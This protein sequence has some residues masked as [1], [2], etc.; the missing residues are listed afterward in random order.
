MS[1]NIKHEC[2]I[3]MLRLRKPPDFYFNKYGTWYYGLQKMYLMMEKQHNRG[4]D[5][6]G[7]AGI[8]INV[9]PGHRYIFRQRS[10]R[11]DPIKEI[12]SLIYEDIDKINTSNRKDL[13]DPDFIRMDMPF[14]CDVYLGH[15][16]YGTYGNYRIDYVH[17]VSRENN[18][19]SKNL[20]MAGNF[21]L[22]NVN[23]VLNHLIDLGQ[24]P[25]D[26]SDT[27]TILENI[28]HRLDEENE[29]LF[30]YFK[31]Q[32][33]SK[34][35]ISPLI[36]ENLDLT[37]ILTKA[38]RNWD[39]G[40]TMAGMVGHGDSFVMRDPAGIRPAFYYI[41][42]EV[43]VVASE[44]PVIQ[45][46]FNV[47]SDNVIELPPAHAIIVKASGNVSVSRLRE[48]AAIR[49]CSFER[50]Y[51]SRG[52][53]KNIYRERK[54]LGELLTDKVLKAVDYDLDNTVFSYIPNTAESAFYG[55]IKGLEDYLNHAKIEAILKMKGQLSR[56]RLESVIKKRP[57]VE[58]IAVK[59]VKLRT[60]IT[61]DKSRDDLVG[62]VYDVTYGVIRRGY[63]NL[64]ILDDSIVRGTTLKKSI[65]RILDRLEPRKII[66]VSSSPQLRYPDCY[67]IDM[68][69][70]GD[71]IAFR[72]AIKLLTEAG[73]ESFIS[74]LYQKAVEE[75]KKPVDEIR[76]L[77]TEIYKSFCPD[78]ISA[79]ISSMLK[80]EEIN[81]DVEILFQSIEGLHQAC[82]GH[83]GDWYF[84][85][86]Y[87]TP[88]GNKVANQS[89]INYV[90]GRNER[91]Y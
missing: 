63:D 22:T 80:T 81:A 47:R 26:F 60:F 13:N 55:L 35:D 11:E 4:Q 46:I 79:K 66:I 31:E 85:G 15:L 12:F 41:D 86:D 20:V 30:R 82:P 70:L 54:K 68:A 48:D 7:I 71:L 19:R 36:E 58:K 43:I 74:E 69:K 1:D 52:T 50:I 90:E 38:S 67:G 51:F 14:V 29:R 91:A 9:P 16:R 17:P 49:K 34:K 33:Y 76:N 5:G 72:A 40:Y 6:A 39:G 45:T 37:T 27:V 28:G 59:D 57:R 62:H 10:N 75:N 32:G 56:E 64:V 8:K 84:T 88:G 65:I 25:I 24:N 18:W 23:E 2:G 61:Q 73:R 78:E 53:D 3:A 83:T 21:N 77:V 42:N 89:F 44:R 87:P